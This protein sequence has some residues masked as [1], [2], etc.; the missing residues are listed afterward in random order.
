MSRENESLVQGKDRGRLLSFGAVN[1]HNVHLQ[2]GRREATECQICS[3]GLE[4]ALEDAPDT[5]EVD[6]R[7]VAE[8]DR[9]D[10]EKA[11]ALARG[12]GADGRNDEVLWQKV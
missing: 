6:K 12:D 2:N 10:K 5:A 7:E 3:G 9:I 4:G 8:S 1:A 11:A